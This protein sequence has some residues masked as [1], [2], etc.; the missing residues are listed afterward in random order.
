MSKT[1][2]ESDD[3]YSNIKN[4]RLKE[5]LED[6]PID[7]YFDIDEEIG[8]DH[9]EFELMELGDDIILEVDTNKARSI[10]I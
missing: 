1:E 6:N 3:R 5:Y 4:Q 2:E 10:G 9:T 7:Q 8:E